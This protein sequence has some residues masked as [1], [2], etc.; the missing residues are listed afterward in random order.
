M[1]TKVFID[2]LSI[3]S[4]FSNFD[5]FKRAAQPLSQLSRRIENIKSQKGDISLTSRSSLKNVSYVTGMNFQQFLGK[6]S[7]NDPH[8][9]S[10][11]RDL[12]GG[13]ISYWDE[14]PRHESHK[15]YLIQNNNVAGTSFSEAWEEESFASFIFILTSTTSHYVTGKQVSITKSGHTKVI[16]CFNN[17]QQLFQKFD[18]IHIKY[19]FND[20]LDRAPDSRETILANT[21]SWTLTARKC[22]GAEVFESSDGKYVSYVDTFHKGKGHHLEVFEISSKKHLGCVSY[23]GT[24][25]PKSLD[26]E[27][28]NKM[29]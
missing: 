17:I 5:D 9:Y 4:Q 28:H 8:F 7:K 13:K 27:K 6:L 19:Y 20:T 18:S 14:N 12:T 26:P 1:P 22:H 3:L 16:D 10:Q 21:Q 15:Q 29:P 25:I 11:W 24:S 23:D 2:E